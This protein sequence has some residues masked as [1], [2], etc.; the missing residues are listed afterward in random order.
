MEGPTLPVHRGPRAD[1]DSDVGATFGA[2]RTVRRLAAG[3][4]GTVFEARHTQTDARAAL[5]LLHAKF[6]TSKEMLARFQRE[7]EIVQAL[8]HPA[9]VRLFDAGVGDDGRPFLCM[10]LLDGHPLSE[11]I[12]ARRRLSLAETT[13]VLSPLCD[14]LAIAHARNIVH[15]D[16][17]ASNVMVCGERVVLLD[18]GIAKISDAFAIELTGAHRCRRLRRLSRRRRDDSQARRR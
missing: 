7:V 1:N 15:R 11:M 14:A 4:F 17:K 5:K 12:H 2:W 13:T 18:F 10:E 3:G 16:V 9:V 8:D 6:A